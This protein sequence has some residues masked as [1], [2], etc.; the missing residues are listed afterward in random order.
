MQVWG[1]RYGVGGMGMITTQI[2]LFCKQFKLFDKFFAPYLIPIPHTHIFLMQILSSE[3][4]HQW[5]AFTMAAEKISSLQLMEKAVSKCLEWLEGGDYLGKEFVIFCGKGNNGADGLMLARKLRVMECGVNVFILDFGQKGS[6]EF[7]SNVAD[8]HDVKSEITFIQ[9][10]EDFP[11][12]TAG[13][14][15]IDALFGSG[16]NRPVEKLTGGLINHLNSTGNEIISVDMPSGMFADNSS[17]ANIIIKATHTL[18]FQI[19]KQALLLPENEEY[20]GEVHVLDIGLSPVFLQTVSANTELLEKTFIRSVYKPRKSFGH[21]G[22]YGHALLVTGS[23]GKMGAAVLSSTACLRTGAGLL[24]VIIPSCGYDIMQVTAP[25]AMVMP[26][27]DAFHVSSSETDF[28]KYNAIGIG[29]GLG[30]EE[31]TVK[32]VDQLLS[33]YHSPLVID[34]DALNIFAT[35]QELLKKIPPFSILTPHPKEFERLFGK[36]GN[37]FER[38]TLAR[39]KAKEL[40]VIIVLKGHRTFIAMPGGKA[41]FNNTG[42]AGMATGGSGDVLTGIL[43]GLLAQ[44]YTPAS[45]VLLG[46]YLHGLAGD[47]AAAKKSQES[48]I[49][50][51]IVSF[52]GDAFL[53]I[54]KDE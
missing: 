35:N 54:N 3:Q 15:I 41:Y 4:I 45:V 38:L 13:A 33:N 5:D 53:S 51:D 7:Q 21:K 47:L 11:E 28:S 22:T 19:L 17:L 23:Y 12:L 30:K 14:I 42:N 6:P 10:A 2:K 24:S 43:T 27:S 32:A 26:G 34:A 50:S 44:A 37:D 46:V 49:A 9:S 18:T 20:F 16:L 29:P 1:M 25:E 39:E 8:F 36:T 40:Q 31:I 52:L 48:M